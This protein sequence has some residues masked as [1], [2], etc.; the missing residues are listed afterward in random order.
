MIIEQIPRDIL[1]AIDNI[2]W[3]IGSEIIFP[4]ELRGGTQTIN[5]ARG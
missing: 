2:D 5:R 3:R 4:S 1:V